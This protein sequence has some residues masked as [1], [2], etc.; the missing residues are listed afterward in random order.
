MPVQAGFRVFKP[1]I[2]TLNVIRNSLLSRMLSQPS[3]RHLNREWAK[4]AQHYGATFTS[5]TTHS[6][7]SRLIPLSSLRAYTSTLFS[8][9]SPTEYSAPSGLIP[10]ISDKFCSFALL[11]RFSIKLQVVLSP[12]ILSILALSLSLTSWDICV[13]I[14]LDTL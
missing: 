7:I 13:S 12:A 5:N 10:Y 3:I 8:F 9:I 4:M 1:G 11:G 2:R 6:D 14:S